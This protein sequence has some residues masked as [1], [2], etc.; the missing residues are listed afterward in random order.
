MKF[1]SVPLALLD[2]SA[3]FS[4]ISSFLTMVWSMPKKPTYSSTSMGL[5][6]ALVLVY[7]AQRGTLLGELGQKQ[8]TEVSTVLI[9]EKLSLR[10]PG[11]G[12]IPL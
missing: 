2:I 3:C 4:R 5:L 9:P 11:A 7:L 6:C 12:C 8:E 10:S 1:Q